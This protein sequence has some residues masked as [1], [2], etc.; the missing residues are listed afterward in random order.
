MASQLERVITLRRVALLLPVV[1][2]LTFL[3]FVVSPAGS[4]V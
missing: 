3:F 2:F 1:M 4:G